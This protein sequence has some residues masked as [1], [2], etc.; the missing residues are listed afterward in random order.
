MNPI[1]DDCLET[2]E[3]A[4]YNRRTSKTERPMQQETV[5]RILQWFIAGMIGLF[6][7]F[8]LGKGERIDRN[9]VY[10]EGYKSGISTGK[11][12]ALAEA[13][14]NDV[15][16]LD[17]KRDGSSSLQRA[18][19][20]EQEIM[21]DPNSPAAIALKAK[22]KEKENCAQY[23]FGSTDRTRCVTEN[24]KISSFDYQAIQEDCAERANNTLYREN[25]V[26]QGIEQVK[27]SP[28][29]TQIYYERRVNPYRR[30]R[31]P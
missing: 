27:T 20:A 21:K 22:T 8:V 7:G 1:S 16:R 13:L 14:H 3:G 28:P 2:S 31:N 10:Q 19:S 9:A 17:A 5:V 26:Q 4:R 25:C 11:S 30:P 24:E 12:Q 23:S 15:A 18:L 6:A 29:P